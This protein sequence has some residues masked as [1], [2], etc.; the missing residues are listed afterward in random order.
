M[1]SCFAA[2]VVA[3]A[4]STASAQR[5]VAH[6]RLVGLLNPSGAEHM[7]AV[8]ARW[9]IGDPAAL[10]FQDA[11]VELGAINYT[12]PIDSITAAYLEVSPLAFLV[13]RAQVGGHVMWPL[14]LNG[15]GFYPVEGYGADV[16]PSRLPGGRGQKAAGSHLRLGATLQGA[17]Q[18]GPLRPI[19]W[20]QLVLEH[21]RLGE[22]AFYYSPRDDAV[23]RREDWLLTSSSMLLLEVRLEPGVDLRLGAYDDLRVVP[24]SGQLSNVAGPAVLLSLA[25]PDPRV[26][27]LLLLVRVAAYTHHRDRA[28]QWTAQAGAIVRYDLGPS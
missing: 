24:G 17:V 26:A 23:L 2:L 14:P 21:R 3:L 6:Q 27:E 11:H 16:R 5:G 19:L 10:L 7:V 15:A 20:T 9:P 28:G 8:G 1:A 22:Q 18:L 12:S 4:P 13:L 25:R